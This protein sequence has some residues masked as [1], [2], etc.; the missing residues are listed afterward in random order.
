MRPH[1]SLLLALFVL[2]A[3]GEV[4]SEERLRLPY[5]DMDACP[6]ECCTY[7]E[8]TVESPTTLRKERSSSAAA[9]FS[10][11][12][13]DLVVGVTGVVITSV[14]GRVVVTREVN[15]ESQ[16]GS[17]VQAKPG[18]VIA[19]LHYLGEGYT[20]AWFQGQLFSI[21][22]PNP[23]DFVYEAPSGERASFRVESQPTA[24]WWVLIK[25]ANGE[26]GWT[27]RTDNFGNIDACG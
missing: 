25:N 13:G 19:T 12:P 20:L 27:D 2:A 9:A 21:E 22:L 7:R 8:W 24:T 11:K 5:E 18:A 16:L 1:V 10:V 4:R 3:P 14:P 15:L 23:P 17:H 6:F 26:R